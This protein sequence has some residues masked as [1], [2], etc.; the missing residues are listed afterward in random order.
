MRIMADPGLTKDMLLGTNRESGDDEGVPAFLQLTD[1]L[2]GGRCAI[3]LEPGDLELT[4]DET[5]DRFL[6]RCPIS[7]YVYERLMSAE[8][9][10]ALRAIQDDYFLLSDE[11]QLMGPVPEV[12]IEQHGITLDGAD[13]PRV[14]RVVADGVPI[15]VVDLTIDRTSAGYTRN[16]SGFHR[17]RWDRDPDRYTN[18]VRDAVE[19]AHPSSEAERILSLESRPDHTELIHCVARRIWDADFESYSRFTGGKRRYRTGD[20]TVNNISDGAGGICSEKVQALKFLTDAY[21]LE[22]SYVLSGPD[23]PAPP[24]EAKLRELLDTFDFGFAKRY[25]RYWQHLALLYSLDGTELLVDATN[26]NIPFLF[27]RGAEAS[28]Y[29]DYDDKRPLPV[30]MAVYPEQFYY[31]RVSQTLV[32]DL[33]FAME[34]FVPEIDLVQVFDNEL[35]LYIGQEVFVTPVVF[36]TDDDYDSLRAEYAKTCRSEGL[37]LEISSSWSLDTPLGRGLQE[38]SPAVAQAIL[39]SEEHLLSRYDYFEGPGH[40]ARLAIIGL[41]APR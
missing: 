28:R 5:L 3:L 14:A 33:Y 18:F 22:S 24:P 20:E 26:G 39:E 1:K 13:L 19:S 27:A 30:R 29:L 16:W 40:R 7:Q 36:L 41:H 23:V 34:H 6:R 10:E 37:P 4:I 9:G 11:G 31:H 25:M 35:G 21:G 32:E 12:T 8:S 38:R 2:T 17:R 15:Q